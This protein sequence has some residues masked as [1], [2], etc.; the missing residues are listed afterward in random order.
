MRRTVVFDYLELICYGIPPEQVA[1]TYRVGSKHLIVR[2]LRLA[3]IV[4]RLGFWKF[5]IRTMDDLILRR[6][7]IYQKLVEH[8]L[9]GRRE[10]A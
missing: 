9:I 6:H 7:A 10:A 5:D 3:R 8:A 2:V 4:G 1:R